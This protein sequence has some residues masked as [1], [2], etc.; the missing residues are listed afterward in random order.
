MNHPSPSR[1]LLCL[2]FVALA[3]C[4]SV[5]PPAPAVAPPSTSPSAPAT[6]AAAT[7][8]VAAAP[9]TP[10]RPRCEADRD[11]CLRDGLPVLVRALSELARS[12]EQAMATLRTSDSPATRA[13]VAY[14]AHHAGD[15]AAANAA[16]AEL[17][18]D[19]ETPEVDEGTTDPAVRALTLARTHAERLSGGDDDVVARLPCVVFAWDPAAAARAFG[20]MHGSTRDELVAP[21]K[22]RCVAEAQAPRVVTAAEAVSRA[23][24]RAW[25]QPDGTIWHAAAIAAQEALRDPL[26]G[27]EGAPL[28]EQDTASRELVTRL[29]AESPELLR[30]LVGYRRAVEGSVGAI[31]SGICA[32][33]RERGRPLTAGQCERRAYAATLTA[34]TLWV[35][36]R[37]GME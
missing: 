31:A 12:P 24:F 32:V 22:R 9:E 25:P 7:A 28:A 11:A 17:A 6:V 20:P 8:P 10:A 19:G 13:W 27:V 21:F 5:P 23:L 34:F 37:L 30:P 14:L 18:R 29:S 3:A 33:S 35:G 4:R 26:L 36:P 16:L 15:D 2:G 1:S